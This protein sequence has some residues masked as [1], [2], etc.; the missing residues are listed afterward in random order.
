MTT[1][2]LRFALSLAWLVL[3][4]L[5]C[6]AAETRAG[7]KT[8]PLANPNAIVDVQHRVLAYSQLQEKIRA[9]LPMKVTNSAAKLGEVEIEFAR[10]VREARAG[11]RPGDIFSPAA[12]DEFRRLIAQAM[13]G[14]G[15]KRIRASLRRAE[16]V[17]LKLN[18]N[19]PYPPNI[20]VQ[21]TPP[22]LL[23]HLPLLPKG[24]DY[25]VVNRDLVLRDSAANLI[26]DFIPHAIP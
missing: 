3:A 20:P 4:T 21:S 17:N 22:T 6:S 19:D 24:L 9:E 16:P 10:R 15:A 1:P 14:P 18:V 5:P 11:A 13:S 26:V 2:F 12:A 7:K 25:R 8:T 23:R